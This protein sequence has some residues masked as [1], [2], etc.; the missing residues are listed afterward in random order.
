[1]KT[2]RKKPLEAYRAVLTLSFIDTSGK[3]VRYA[4]DNFLALSLSAPFTERHAIHMAKRAFNQ[5][6]HEYEVTQ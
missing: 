3:R 6:R 5:I 2:K 4:Q 1:M